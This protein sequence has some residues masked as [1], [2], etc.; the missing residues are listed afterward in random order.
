MSLFLFPWPPSYDFSRERICL[1]ALRRG[2]DVRGNWQL[3]FEISAVRKKKKIII[4]KAAAKETQ[5]QVLILRLIYKSFSKREI[6]RERV[7][8]ICRNKDKYFFFLRYPNTQIPLFFPFILS[9]FRSFPVISWLYP[10]SK[11]VFDSIFI[12]PCSISIDF[13]V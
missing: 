7:A 3:V 12:S 10:V 11:S 6:E 13:I 9:F 4:S 8:F 1:T 2:R 5:P